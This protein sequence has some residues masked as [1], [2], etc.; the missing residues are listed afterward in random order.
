MD[1][2]TSGSDPTTPLQAFANATDING[3]D[4][5]LYNLNVFYNVGILL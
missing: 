5:K 4:S 3:G 1:P 2:V